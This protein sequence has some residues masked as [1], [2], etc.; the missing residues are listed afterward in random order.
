VSA[1]RVRR[2]ERV[3][4]LR[5]RAVEAAQAS[6]AEAARRVIEAEDAARAAEDQWS[7]DG[8]APVAA[9]LSS[10]ELADASGWLRA[11]RGRADRA[12]A[13]AAEARAAAQRSQEAL[14]GA[15]AE[16]RRIELWRDGLVAAVRAAQDRKDRV[17]ADEVAARV[18]RRSP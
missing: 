4:E 3:V 2:A 9:S 7:R 16:L 6:V 11:L 15:R 18:A 10:A 5:R 17:A 14:V 12:A 8:S 1:E 13:Q